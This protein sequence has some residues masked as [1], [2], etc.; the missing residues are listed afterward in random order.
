MPFGAG[1][2]NFRPPGWGAVDGRSLASNGPCTT[3]HTGQGERRVRLTSRAW[4]GAACWVLVAG[5]LAAAD[6]DGRFAGHGP[7][8]ARCDQ[9]VQALSV[10]GPDR[11]L[12]V[13]WVAGFL[14]AANAFRAN[15][16]DVAPWQPVEFVA[17]VIAEQCSRNPQAAV[18][19]VTLAVVDQLAEDRLQRS[20]EVV[21][22]EHGGA[23]VSIYR[24]VLRQVQTRL[25]DL[26][27][28]SGGIDGAYGPMTRSALEA[29]QQQRGVPTTGVP[30]DVT[31]LALFYDLVP[32]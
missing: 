32:Q 20:S 19:E 21:N 22:V 29:F 16:Y 26:G 14:T 7:G 6:G 1:I 11:P 31:L 8:I 13:G 27:H 9:L 17:N 3:G 5:P 4:A 10:D 15:T 24:D 28:Y 25:R 12:F 30:D 23:R 18:T 2:A